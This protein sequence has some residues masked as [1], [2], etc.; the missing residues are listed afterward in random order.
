MLYE[1][2]FEI[3]TTKSRVQNSRVSCNDCSR[4]FEMSAQPTSLSLR[5]APIFREQVSIA[6]LILLDLDL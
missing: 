5:I 2:D 6:M 1:D 3:V 4:H